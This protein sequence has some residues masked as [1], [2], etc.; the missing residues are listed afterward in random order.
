M[1]HSYVVWNFVNNSFIFGICFV[2]HAFPISSEKL[3]FPQI[4]AFRHCT[5]HFISIQV[6]V[7]NKFS[8][9]YEVDKV[10]YVSIRSKHYFSLDENMAEQLEYLGHWRL[11]CGKF[12]AKLEHSKSE[13]KF[14]THPSH[15]QTCIVQVYIDPPNCPQWRAATAE[16][17]S[18]NILSTTLLDP[19]VDNRLNWYGDTLGQMITWKWIFVHLKK[20]DYCT[21]PLPYL[22]EIE[23]VVRHQLG[24]FLAWQATTTVTLISC[25]SEESANDGSKSITKTYLVSE[26]ESHTALILK[27]KRNPHLRDLV[28]KPGEISFPESELIYKLHEINFQ[29]HPDFSSLENVNQHMLHLIP[30]QQNH[31]F[32]TS[33]DSNIYPTNW[34]QLTQGIGMVLQSLIF[35]SNLT[36]NT[37]LKPDE[38]GVVLLTGTLWTK[39]NKYLR[40]TWEYKSQRG[41]GTLVFHDVNRLYFVTCA[42]DGAIGLSIKGLVSAFDGYVWLLIFI[43][44]L[45]TKLASFMV[46][47]CLGLSHKTSSLYHNAFFIYQILLCQGVRMDRNKF[48][49]I[50]WLG[51]GIVLSNAYNGENISKLSAPL[52]Y[53]KF[54]TFRQVLDQN[55]TIY[56]PITLH[57]KRYREYFE[58]SGMQG[59]I[60]FSTVGDINIEQF[61]SQDK[62]KIVNSTWIPQTENEKLGTLYDDYFLPNMTQCGKA[63]FLAER[64]V[65][66][67]MFVN[68]KKQF[69]MKDSSH[70]H[71]LAISDEP[72]ERKSFKLQIDRFPMPPHTLIRW[73][74]SLTDFGLVQF[75]ITWTFRVCDRSYLMESGRGVSSQPRKLSITSN[76]S[77]IFLLV[78]GLLM[79]VVL[80]VFITEKLG[81]GAQI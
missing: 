40:G 45:L 34:N 39:V 48:M 7:S 66:T 58:T 4:T 77:G 65:V 67:E 78:L 27:L 61:V 3:K 12:L 14:R 30:F 29:D 81:F 36:A 11:Q 13:F 79:I 64:P 23:H 21:S 74:H 16:S 52:K 20:A 57:Y 25:I 60:I 72:F 69:T 19:V 47:K 9:V 53:L 32:P 56:S 10:D 55:F 22:Y 42:S 1:Y 5:L 44:T 18:E 49:L 26:I 46:E 62:Q 71:Y 80:L 63:I 17:S 15:R 73:L 41:E 50:S 43:S 76:I 6:D 51:M 37:L 54:D 2:L 31:G 75:W 33:D 38:N 59:W 24:Y 35:K 8:D 70:L 68:L 28:E